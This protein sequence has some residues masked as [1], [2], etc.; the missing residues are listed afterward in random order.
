MAPRA[1]THSERSGIALRVAWTVVAV[2]F[3]LAML[4][5]SFLYAAH[6]WHDLTLWR[7]KHALVSLVA[8]PRGSTIIEER[9]FFGSRYTDTSECTFVVGELRS[10]LLSPQETL[11]AY[12]NVSVNLFGFAHDIKAQAVII[13]ENTST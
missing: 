7:M 13:T 4:V 3:A 5:I 8:H 10:T 1:M 2:T 6:P 11:R 12:E 9:S